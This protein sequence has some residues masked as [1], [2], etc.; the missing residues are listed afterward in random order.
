MALVINSSNKNND[1]LHHRLY[2]PHLTCALPRMSS[3]VQTMLLF[4]YQFNSSLPS[5]SMTLSVFILSLQHAISTHEHA[6][7]GTNPFVQLT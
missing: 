1:G 7:C 2:R 4:V 5:D 3:N 6:T